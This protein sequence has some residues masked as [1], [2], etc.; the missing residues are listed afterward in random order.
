MFVNETREDISKRR[1]RCEA[2]GR[3]R[4]A[5]RSA[6]KELHKHRTRRHK[7]NQ[8]EQTPTRERRTKGT[9]SAELHGGSVGSESRSGKQGRST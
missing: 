5:L 9:A 4:T 6:R 3:E 1:R 8:T 2:S 7:A